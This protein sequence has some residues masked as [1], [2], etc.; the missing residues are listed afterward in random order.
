MCIF[1]CFYLFHFCL[2]KKESDCTEMFAQSQTDRNA[3]DIRFAK[4]VLIFHREFLSSISHYIILDTR[5]FD[6]ISECISELQKKFISI[7]L[8][9][10]VLIKILICKY[11]WWL[12]YTL[13]IEFFLLIEFPFNPN[14]RFFTIQTVVYKTLSHFPIGFFIE[15]YWKYLEFKMY[16]I[17]LQN[18]RVWFR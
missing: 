16:V 7:C 3:I 12:W 5:T 2:P 8:I 6:C 14:W 10:D 18:T 4:Y 1:V 15:E 13:L 11:N 9:F 17:I